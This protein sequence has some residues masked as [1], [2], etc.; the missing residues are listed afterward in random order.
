MTLKIADLLNNSIAAAITGRT[1]LSMQEI[2]NITM[3]LCTFYFERHYIA[4][5]QWW[6]EFTFS[7]ES[8]V[9]FDETEL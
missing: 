9:T 2:R 4:G 5:G 6:T 1:G 7:D 8:S 3:T